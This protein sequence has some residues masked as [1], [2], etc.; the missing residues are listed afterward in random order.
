MLYIYIC[1]YIYVCVYYMYIYITWYEFCVTCM[2]YYC[3]VIITAYIYT[4][5]E[6][7]R[8]TGATRYNYNDV[9]LIDFDKGQTNRLQQT[10]QCVST[11]SSDKHNWTHFGYSGGS[12]LSWIIHTTSQ[13]NYFE[14]D[15]RLVN[16]S[17]SPG[18]VFCHQLPA[19]LPWT[20]FHV[21]LEVP[22]P[23]YWSEGPRGERASR[24]YSQGR[25]WKL[26]VAAIQSL[27][28]WDWKRSFIWCFRG[29]QWSTDSSLFSLLLVVFIFGV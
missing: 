21:Q 22:Y 28:I 27:S 16:S 26:T 7:Q 25:P 3:T 10:F 17:F 1:M 14:T 19:V 9:G 23:S 18:S 2:V 5:R 13:S 20:Q 8:K 11:N 29:R 12:H 24:L 6:S 4:E 15:L